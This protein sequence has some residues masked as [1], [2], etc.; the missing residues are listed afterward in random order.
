M[1]IDKEAV[2]NDTQG[3]KNVIHLN[4]AGSSLMPNCVFETQLN[5][6]TLEASIGGYEAANCM[7][8]QIEAV[9]DSISRLIN[10]HRDEIAIVENATVGWMMAFYSIPFK[11]GDRILTCEAEYASN[12]LAYLQVAKQKGVIIEVI[13]SNTEGEICISSLE[14]M[15]DEQ[16]KLVS[17]THVPTNGG[18]INPVEEIGAITKRQNIFYIVDACQSAGQIPLD[19]ESI[20]CD[21]L[22]AT[23][24]KYL[25]GPRGVGFL[26]VR[27][28]VIK[29]LHPPMID[30]MSA[31]WTSPS[32]YELRND[33]RRFENWENNYS[34]KLGL[35]SAVDYAL[36]IGIENIESA[37]VLLAEKLRTMLSA[38]PCVTVQDI[39]K[40]K[41]GIV[42][43]TVDGFTAPS[44]VE[45]LHGKNINV[46]SSCPSS[47]LID[48]TKRQLPDLV[49]ASVHYY[50]DE[51]EIN[52]FIHTLKEIIG[53]KKQ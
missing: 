53:N 45:Q 26:F 51:K 28:S 12:Y 22:S 3:K 50:N 13:P 6:L 31:I 46:S 19:V 23:S 41:C 44:I 34:A 29:K 38:I 52:T 2:F 10:C 30:L 14:G 15:I 17:V 35:G 4:N 5:H 8:D 7:S 25:R 33:A 37:V 40:N 32:S 36:N 49:R 42:T 9:Y 39:G 27:K 47:T 21:V 16:V 1:P 11:K 24:R 18:L 43:F 48:A 20:Q